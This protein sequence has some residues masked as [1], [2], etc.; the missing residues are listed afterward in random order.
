MRV[1]SQCDLLVLV[2]SQELPLHGREEL[3]DLRCCQHR[4]DGRPWLPMVRLLL[5][6]AAVNFHI[7]RQH[8]QLSKCEVQRILK[9]CGYVRIYSFTS[10]QRNQISK[11]AKETNLNE[12]ASVFFSIFH[13][14]EIRIFKKTVAGVKYRERGSS[15]L[16]HAQEA[17]RDSSPLSLS[18]CFLLSSCLVYNSYLMPF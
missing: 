4:R 9:C 8:L 10:S 17:G 2:I 6:F 15:I 16:L 5:R 14:F 3:F 7:F 1:V 18:W 11:R 12:G 13:P